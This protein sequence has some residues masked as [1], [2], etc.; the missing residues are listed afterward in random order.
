MHA[1]QRIDADQPAVQL[2]GEDHA[3]HEE[4]RPHVHAE[5]D[6][7]ADEQHSITHPP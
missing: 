3:R 7:Q 1:G 2:E 5:K 6:E 4:R